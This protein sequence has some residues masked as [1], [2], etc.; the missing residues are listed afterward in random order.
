MLVDCEK[1]AVSGRRDH[2]ALG[3]YRTF[4]R[5]RRYKTGVIAASFVIGFLAIAACV[6][7]IGADSHW[8]WKN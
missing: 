8:I 5:R 6:Y 7:F 2:S 1:H 3:F 4:V